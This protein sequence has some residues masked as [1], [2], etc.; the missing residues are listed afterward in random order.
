MRK[1]IVH[2]GADKM[3]YEVLSIVEL[4]RELNALGL[5]IYWENIGDPI[6]KGLSLPSWFK[7]IV[8]NSLQ[9]D[10]LYG[11]S[12]TKGLYQTR[13][14]WADISLRNN[15]KYISPDDIIF[16]NGLGDAINKIFG[17]LKRTARVLVPSPGYMTYASGE[18]AHAGALPVSYYLHP[19]NG[20]CP[21][22]AD[23][24]T[25]IRYNPSVV[26]ILIVNPDNPTGFVYPE[27]ILREIV[28]LA[29]KYNLFVIVDEVYENIV[30]NDQVPC[31]LGKYIGDV[32]GIAL[33]S[34]SKEMP[35]PG[36]RCGW[37]E[38]YNREKDTGFDAY[39]NSIV[40]AKMLE[41]CSTTLPQK[42]LPIL[43][44]HPGYKSFLQERVQKYQ[45]RANIAYKMFCGEEGLIV[46]PS[47]GA[48]YFTVVF[49]T[50]YLSE[51]QTLPVPNNLV[52]NKIAQLVD[53]PMMALD[54]RFSLYLLGNTG[55]C[56]VPLS[57]FNTEL[58]GLRMT[59][60]EEDDKRFLW[61][62]TSIR[63]SLRN[64]LGTM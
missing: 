51:D 4:A 9:S 54:K 10:E 49:Q 40:N 13:K 22:V 57:S 46:N 11:Y 60:L 6:S 8:S 15:G 1:D 2:I 50:N 55:I 64:Y 29:R 3:H 37:M 19:Q 63:D 24:E 41:V 25:R 59:L 39:I 26:A 30:F 34:M 16:F 48:F 18:A 36:A 28:I 23:I 53:A 17:F 47:N 45:E 44:A 14:F 7:E 58:Q 32:P 52:S 20:W 35:W 27:K 5:D 33:K 56:V 38:V 12:P 62:V 61:T 21:D 43:M 31:S 42:V